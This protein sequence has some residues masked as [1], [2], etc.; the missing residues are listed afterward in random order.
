[1]RTQAHSLK[2]PSLRPCAFHQA[3]LYGPQRRTCYEQFPGGPIPHEY[4]GKSPSSSSQQLRECLA[5]LERPPLH[6][7][8]RHW[9][10]RV[11]APN[12]SSKQKPQQKQAASERQFRER[13]P[14]TPPPPFGALPS[15]EPR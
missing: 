9:P 5:S 1:M 8:Y 10:Q 11:A 14:A 7:A 13:S 3:L 15:A 4:L 2:D 6:Y 12:S